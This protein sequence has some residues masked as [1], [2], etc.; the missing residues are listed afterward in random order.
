MNYIFSK[1]AGHSRVRLLFVLC[2]SAWLL[3]FSIDELLYRID[4]GNHFEAV[5]GINEIIG[6]YSFAQAI[7]LVVLLGPFIETILFQILLLRAIRALTDRL[8]FTEGWG[9][10]FVLTSLIFAAIH[11]LG[12]ESVYHGLFLVIPILPLAF[13]LSLL[14]VMEY[15]REDGAPVSYVFVLHAI[16]NAITSILFF[17]FR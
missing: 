4:P 3:A 17:S 13:A 2:T 16:Y 12:S 7:F 1:F 14:A 15:E 5:S 11:G 9:P 6:S 8:P 10:S